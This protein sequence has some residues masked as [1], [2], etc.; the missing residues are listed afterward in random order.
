[1][2]RLLLSIAH[3]LDARVWLIGDDK[4]HK[5]VARGKPFPL[6]MEKAGLTP[7]WLTEVMRQSGDYRKAVE[8][9]LDK[10]RAGFDRPVRWAGR[11]E[12][13]LPSDTVD[14]VR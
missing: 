6:L 3:D 13:L 12:H 9:V 7:I 2:E 4:Q 5:A 8:L 10:P 11:R 1:M 14:S